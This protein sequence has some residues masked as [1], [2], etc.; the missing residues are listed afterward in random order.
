MQL[1]E[2]HVAPRGQIAKRGECV[3]PRSLYEAHIACG[4]SADPRK[5]LRGD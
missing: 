5:Q 2:L 1:H 3:Y 4:V